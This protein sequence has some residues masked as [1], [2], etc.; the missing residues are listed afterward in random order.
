M[1]LQPCLLWTPSF[2]E[3]SV[4][5]ASHTQVLVCP[6]LGTKKTLRVYLGQRQSTGDAPI[7]A[8]Q[9]NLGGEYESEVRR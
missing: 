2:S 4:C 5:V 3:S 8:R 1:P 6:L 7:A 9:V